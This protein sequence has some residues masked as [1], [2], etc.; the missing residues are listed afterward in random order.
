MNEPLVKKNNRWQMGLGM[1]L[2]VALVACGSG[3][4]ASDGLELAL[5]IP[6]EESADVFWF[7]VERR[8]ITIKEN[9]PKAR[10]L[11]WATGLQVEEDLRRGDRIVFRGFDGRG[12]LVVWG[13]A[14]VGEEK[15]VSV[16]L[17]RVL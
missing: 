5:A 16:P 11:V 13:E 14:V 17:R 7:G 12:R 4:P 10:T 6:S 15:T 3:S 9:D 1:L 2:T 8:E